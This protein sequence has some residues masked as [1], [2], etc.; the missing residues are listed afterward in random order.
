MRM[1]RAPRLLLAALAT[2][3]TLLW[4]APAVAAVQ[5]EIDQP[6]RFSGLNWESNLVLAGIERFIVERG[7]GCATS[8]EIGETLA[9]LAALQRRAV[10]VTPEVWPGQIEV[11]WNKALKSGKVLAAGH[12]YDARSEEHTSDLQSLM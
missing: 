12:V 7:Y 6:V 4:A 11:A 1:T 9:M 10:D 3:T 2:A 5:C 8:V